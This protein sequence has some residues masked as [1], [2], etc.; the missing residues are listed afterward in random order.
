[1]CAVLRTRQILERI[2]RH[3]QQGNVHMQQGNVHMERGNELIGRIDAHMERGNELAAS[4]QMLV[5]ENRAAMRQLVDRNEKA[6]GQLMDRNE[7]VNR[8]TVRVLS[9]L[10]DDVKAH[11]AAIWAILDRLPPDGGD[12][13]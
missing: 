1:M 6:I 12:T 10:G 9:E 4:N 7:R 11:T 2:D 8:E 5:Q 13:A 3:M